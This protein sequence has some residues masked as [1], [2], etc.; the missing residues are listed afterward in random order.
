[1]IGIIFGLIYLNQKKNQDGIQNINGVIFLCITNASF[2]NLFAVVNVR[3]KNS[4]SN[5]V[6]ILYTDMFLI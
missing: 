6:K 2:S 1:M 5:V 4:S 3:R